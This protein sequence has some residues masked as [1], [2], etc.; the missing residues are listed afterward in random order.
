[1]RAR[2]TRD[3]R[4]IYTMRGEE[5]FTSTG[6]AEV[7]LFSYEANALDKGWIV[8]E[9]YVWDA[10]QTR[11]K[12]GN[13]EVPDQTYQVQMQLQTDTI[14]AINFLSPAENRAFG[15]FTTNYLLS[16]K[17][18]YNA[19]P[20]HQ[21]HI[22]DPDHM[23]TRELWA[24]FL[25]AGASGLESIACT[26]GYLIVLEKVKTSPAENILQTVKGV[27]QDIQN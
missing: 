18:P 5:T 14:G 17:T 9:A 2:P 4:N 12:G 10:G 3:G 27:A 7:H 15:W 8:R 13:D 26:I 16:S 1:M 11:A 6:G 24:N 21:M 25:Y 19:G 23:I 20:I 22:L